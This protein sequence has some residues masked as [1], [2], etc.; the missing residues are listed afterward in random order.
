[1]SLTISY[2]GTLRNP[3]EADILL[4]DVF[5]LCMEMGW[6][7]MP[8]H[9][10]N[11]MPAKGV[12]IDPKG[13]ETI[14]LAFL[15]N[16]K[17]YNPFHFI[18]TMH[19]EKEIVNEELHQRIFVKTRYAGMDTHIAIMK[20][21]RYLSSKYFETFT[22]HDP[23]GYYETGNAADCAEYFG[24]FANPYDFGAELLED[25]DAL[26]SDSGRMDEALWNRCSPEISL[27]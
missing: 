17:L 19:P 20:F 4:G 26:E 27:N 10:S 21:F 11:I 9:R 16:G 13:C 6:H 1:M 18:Y 2:C 8:I 14:I 15:A 7:Y 22:L 23:S 24:V 12:M 5:D 25:D 3:E